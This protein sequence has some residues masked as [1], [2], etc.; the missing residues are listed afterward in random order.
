MSK[1]T[2]QTFNVMVKATLEFDIPV[3][4]NTLE[5]ALQKSK[6]LDITDVAEAAAKVKCFSDYNI[7]IT[8]V[9]HA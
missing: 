1:K 5:E 2:L 7:D 3:T 8:G 6:D 9:F 4:A